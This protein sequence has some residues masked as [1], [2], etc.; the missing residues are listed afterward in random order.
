MI[1]IDLMKLN[2]CLNFENPQ[3]SGSGLTPKNGWTKTPLKPL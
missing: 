2:F 3:I 1:K